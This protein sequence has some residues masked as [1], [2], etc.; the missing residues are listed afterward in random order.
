[1]AFAG[2]AMAADGLVGTPPV[3]HFAPD[4]EVHP[5]NFAVAQGPDGIV[6]VGNQEGVLEFDGEAWRLLR[7]P[8]EDMVRSLQ[9]APD[10]RIYVGGYNT[11]GY[12]VRD[13]TGK[14]AFHELA[15]LFA[16]DLAKREFADIWDIVLA[17]EGVYFRAVRDVFLWNPKGGATRYWHHDG[18][19][20]ALAH[21]DGR[22]LLQFRGEGFKRRVGAGW[23]LLP[24]TAPLVD[25]VYG[26]LPLAD[27]G[28]LTRSID[29]AWWRLGD[30]RLEPVTMPAG[31]PASSQFENGLRLGDGTLALT[32]R[33][34]VV[35]LVAPDRASERHFK[36]A[37]GFLNDI[38]PTIDGGFLVATE[39]AVHRVSWPAPWNV[40][41]IEHGADGSLNAVAN[42]E[43]QRYLLTS[44]GALR[45]VRTAGG[46][47]VFEAVPW[48]PLG[49]YDV[50]GIA[51]HRALLAR[52][53]KL[54]VVD[55]GNLRDASPELVYPR[56]LRQSRFDP[57]RVFVGTELGLRL[58][59]LRGGVP[60]L[61]PP[62]GDGEAMRINSIA[63]IADGEVWTGSD[64]H[65]IWKHVIAADGTLVARER[66]GEAQG[67]RMGRIP[68]GWVERMA[69]GSLVASTREGWFRFDGKR[70]VELEFSRLSQARKPGELLRLVQSPT[71]ELWA[72]GVTRIFHRGA[73]ETWREEQVSSFR[74]GAIVDHEFEPD[75]RA[76]F[77]GGQALLLHDAGA[78]TKPAA[79]PRLQMR[80]VTLI[81]PDGRLE[82][83]PLATRKAVRLPPGD[84]G[85][86]FEFAL[87]ELGREDTQLYRG[88]LVGYEDKFSDW[89]RSH[90][91]T[92]SRLRP[93]NY[94]L[95]LEAMDSLGRVSKLGGY[96]IRSEPQWYTSY[97]ARLLGVLVL[98][99][100][101]GML[102]QAYVRQRT[103]SIAQQKRKL[104]DTVARRTGE[105]ADA[106]R[107]LEMMANID[108]L[109]G[110][111][112]RRRLDEYLA[113]VWQQCGDRGRPL[114]LLAI[115]VDR[116]KDFNDR[117]G[118]LA[119]DQL[120][121]LIVERLAHCLRRAEDLLARYGGE[122]FLVVLP[123]ADLPI[124]AQLAEV[125]RKEVEKSGLGATVS[126]GVASRV[127]DDSAALTELVARADAALYV[128][129]KGGR[130]RIEIA[131]ATRPNPSGTPA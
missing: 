49:I 112:N 108:G 111:P 104:E 129:K 110:I 48:E 71:G 63:E 122:E 114:S 45:A 85:I 11:F 69:D 25:L 113:A 36:V 131:G 100:V 125:M 97:G 16:K 41:G 44:S 3:L 60:I 21:H 22:T 57:A 74:R 65:G 54:M 8:N 107:R 40:L 70:F 66:V 51:P 43:G 103:H 89:A 130:N 105:L 23:E 96:A 29:G 90:R 39:Q 35:W 95:E 10:G 34:G 31:L 91:Y 84:A 93:G 17:P 92:F 124:A 88:R 18:R 47:M 127:P 32:S 56:L 117:E 62:L 73:D 5:R 118:H 14:L 98:L 42:W 121:R 7:L 15:G 75:G 68:E 38:A 76:V 82:P 27:G 106:N 24:E 9:A 123:G 72:Y 87:P 99:L 1:M 86:R 83:L 67:L 46:S 28:L 128:A 126:I 6:Y 59:T 19:F 120:L 20:G 64:R 2:I 115:D 58:V 4:F 37:S 79:P 55:G 77:V 119:G 102:T 13:A 33:D 50:L 94:R 80:A 12:L 30:G 116:F 52:S 78:N 53:H 61:S 26:L 81:H 109:T 101:L